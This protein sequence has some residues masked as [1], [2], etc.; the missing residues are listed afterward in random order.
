MDFLCTGVSSLADSNETR[1]GN[2]NSFPSGPLQFLSTCNLSL[3]N[4]RSGHAC[5]TGIALKTTSS[6][7]QIHTANL[8]CGI[9]KTKVSSEHTHVHTHRHMGTHSY[10]YQHR[11]TCIHKH[12]HTYAHTLIHINLEKPFMA[13]QQSV[14]AG[15][16]PTA[17]GSFALS[18]LFLMI[19]KW[20]GQL[21]LF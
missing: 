8:L 3:F 12:V 11:H 15:A 7:D 14:P 4:L 9:L 16:D 19:L 6:C 2:I 18:F 20:I 1:G 21:F 17:S 5:G 13:F 10:T